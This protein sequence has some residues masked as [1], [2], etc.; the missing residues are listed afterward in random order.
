MMTIDLHAKVPYGGDERGIRVYTLIAPTPQVSPPFSLCLCPSHTYTHAQ[1]HKAYQNLFTDAFLMKIL[2]KKTTQV[3]VHDV[4]I[5]K[6]CEF[7]NNCTL[8]H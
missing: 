5:Y 6:Y 1:A 3:R 7:K 8:S 4:F 2:L